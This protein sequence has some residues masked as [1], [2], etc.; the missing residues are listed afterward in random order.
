[1]NYL[2]FYLRRNQIINCDSASLE[3]KLLSFIYFIYF[4]LISI[5]KNSEA[6]H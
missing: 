2:N 6:Y 4:K 3:I 1:M 5:N